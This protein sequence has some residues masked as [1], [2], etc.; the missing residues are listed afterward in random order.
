ML[1]KSHAAVL[2]SILSPS[3]GPSSINTRD[4]LPPLQAAVRAVNSHIAQMWIMDPLQLGALGREEQAQSR[5]KGIL[6]DLTGACEWGRRMDEILSSSAEG[7]AEAE[8]FGTG[9]VRYALEELM[10]DHPLTDYAPRLDKIWRRRS[11]LM[12]EENM[13][14]EL[15]EFYV[16][17]LECGRLEDVEWG[18]LIALKL[19]QVLSDMEIAQRSTPSCLFTCC[20]FP[21]PHLDAKAGN[22]FWPLPLATRSTEREKE[23]R[24]IPFLFFRSQNVTGHFTTF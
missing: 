5:L 11:G 3:S 13:D 4:L 20:L 14:A 16:T 22:S 19:P 7:G 18:C 23:A 17:I 21:L 2:Q 10:A 24:A 15:E 12:K 1:E 9:D 8:K 6:E